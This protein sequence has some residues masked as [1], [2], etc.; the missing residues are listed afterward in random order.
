MWVKETVARRE[1]ID[2]GL[3][4]VS[5]VYIMYKAWMRYGAQH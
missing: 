5:D 3:E 1:I 4:Y 2:N